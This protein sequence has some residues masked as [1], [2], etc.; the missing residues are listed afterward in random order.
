MEY[1]IS[2]DATLSTIVGEDG[3]PINLFERDMIALKA[4]MYA[5]FLTVQDDAF[6]ALKP[7]GEPAGAEA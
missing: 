6:A 2:E 5:A 7:A 1:S 4:T 3:Q